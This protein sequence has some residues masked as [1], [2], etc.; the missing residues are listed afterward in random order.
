MINKNETARFI[1]INMRIKR[2]T[3]H[4]I[5]CAHLPWRSYKSTQL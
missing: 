1:N 3:T 5:I 4:A 2:K